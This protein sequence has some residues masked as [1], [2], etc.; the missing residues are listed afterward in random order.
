MRQEIL[1]F[2]LSPEKAMQRR[3][4]RKQ[5]WCGAIGCTLGIAGFVLFVV[6]TDYDITMMLPAVIPGLVIGSGWSVAKLYAQHREADRV[7]LGNRALRL[8]QFGKY[9]QIEYADVGGLS[10]FLADDGFNTHYFAAELRSRSGARLGRF[11]EDF[12]D[13]E[14][15]Y[16][17]LR[18]RLARSGIFVG[19]DDEICRVRRCRKRGTLRAQIG[20][21]LFGVAICLFLAVMLDGERREHETFQSRAHIA[22]AVVTRHFRD[23]HPYLEIKFT[24]EQ[25]G[26]HV[27]ERSI[28]LRRWRALKVGDPV[29]V[30]YL[31]D[32]PETTTF[33]IQGTGPHIPM[34]IACMVFAILL[35]VGV[36]AAFRGYCLEFFQRKVVLLRPGEVIEDRH[37]KQLVQSFS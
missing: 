14:Y 8:Y 4:H 29:F 15:L 37:E 12:P 13:F 35:A 22:I 19:D 33:E 30:Y 16:D 26:E 34:T 28:E 25:G 6:I 18:R 20:F 2:A 24:D 9:R 23:F 21:C 32:D 1:S 36:F 10:S 5:A 7:D 27:L 31:A 17:E 11:T 3:K